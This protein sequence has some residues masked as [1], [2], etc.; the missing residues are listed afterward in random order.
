MIRAI[1]YMFISNSL[2]TVF[3]VVWPSSALWPKITRTYGE[4]ATSYHVK[5]GS[6]A[7]KLGRNTNPS[8]WARAIFM[9]LLQR[10]GFPCVSVLG[11]D[12]FDLY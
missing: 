7:L 10:S 11:Y 2:G 1:R 4:Y 5:E 8:L 6:M 3:V 12:I 9:V